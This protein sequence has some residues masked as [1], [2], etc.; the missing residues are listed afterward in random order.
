M[1]YVN[2]LVA[3]LNGLIKEGNHVTPIPLEN[4]GK[5]GYPKEYVTS[6]YGPSMY[7]RFGNQKYELSKSIIDNV[8]RGNYSIRLRD[9]VNSNVTDSFYIDIRDMQCCIVTK[10]ED[11][12]VKQLI[13]VTSTY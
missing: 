11:V 3:I 4:F 9:Y 13:A 7:S 5:E 2:A 12:E 10:N 8:K 1:S 6:G